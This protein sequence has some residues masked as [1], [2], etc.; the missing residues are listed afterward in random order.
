M[1]NIVKPY[2]KTMCSARGWTLSINK[3][4][5]DKARLKVFN[6]FVLK[7]VCSVSSGTRLLVTTKLCSNQMLGSGLHITRPWFAFILLQN[8]FWHECV[9]HTTTDCPASW[10]VGRESI[11]NVLLRTLDCVGDFGWLFQ[12][13]HMIIAW[14]CYNVVVIIKLGKLY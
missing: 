4:A 6:I 10:M 8:M 2:D 14:H 1:W 13:L 3:K 12:W 9:L 11:P 5:Q 7:P